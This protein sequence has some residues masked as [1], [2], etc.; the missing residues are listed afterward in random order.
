MTDPW[1]GP[2][3]GEGDHLPQRSWYHWSLL[4][5]G[6]RYLIATVVIG[7]GLGVLMWTATA[8]PPAACPECEVRDHVGVGL[9][10]SGDSIQVRFIACEPTM[11]ERVVLYDQDGATRWD[12][13]ATEPHDETVFLTDQVYGAFDEVVALGD[14]PVSTDLTGFVEADRRYLF[15]FN[16]LDLEPGQVF[17][18]YR[19]LDRATFE[20]QARRVACPTLDLGGNQARLLSIALL[21]VLGV[22]AYLGSGRLLSGDE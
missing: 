3:P 12:I 18:R 8:R 10:P 7:I 11:V 2:E 4:T 5:P 21:A 19:L 15:E 16:V 14:L 13:Q 9:T 22:V 6:Q 1:G 17:Y 20:D